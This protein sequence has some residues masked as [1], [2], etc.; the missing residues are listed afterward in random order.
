MELVNTCSGLAIQLLSCLGTVVPTVVLQPF[1]VFVNFVLQVTHQVLPSLNDEL[2]TL[3]MFFRF[4]CFL[5]S[6]CWSGYF[7]VKL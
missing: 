4:R 7:N 3:P 1:A 2:Y 5:A 6:V